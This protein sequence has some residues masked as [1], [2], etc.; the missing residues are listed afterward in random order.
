MTE[1]P[2]LEVSRP[3][4]LTQGEADVLRILNEVL[5]SEVDPATA[6]ANL[7][8]SLREHIS[9]QASGSLGIASELLWDLWA[10]LLEVVGTVS[11][12][13]PWHEVLIAAVDNLRQGGGAVA[14]SGDVNNHPHDQK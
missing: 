12:D 14:A 13:H 3:E 9:S 7:A 10:I 1:N 11:I 4:E 8:R 2:K 6:S 5:T